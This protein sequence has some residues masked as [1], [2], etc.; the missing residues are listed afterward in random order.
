M[1]RDDLHGQQHACA[2]NRIFVSFLYES[3]ALVKSI[4]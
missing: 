1:N 4:K 3:V 2:E